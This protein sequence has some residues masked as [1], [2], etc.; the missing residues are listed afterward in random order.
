M[1]P[2]EAGFVAPVLP[3][4]CNPQELPGRLP[5]IREIEAAEMTLPCIWPA[6][7][8]RIVVVRE[9]F[10]V[11]YGIPLLVNGNEGHA[12]MLLQGIPMI[13][14]L[15]A[16]YHHEDKMFLVM[17]YMPGKSLHLVWE[18]MSEQDK[19]GVTRQLHDTFAC[20]RELVPPS[21]PAF[22]N[23]TGGPVPQRFFMTRSKDPS[24]TGPFNNEAAF[25]H[26]MA[27]HLREDEDRNGMAHAPSHFLERHLDTAMGR[28]ACV[29]THGDLQPK[30]IIVIE[31]PPSTLYADKNGDEESVPLSS[32][33]TLSGVVD[34]ENAG[35]MPSYWEYA[36]MFV[37]A[38]WPD[39]WT[40]W[41]ESILD[42][43]PSESAM[44]MF[45]RR[46]FDGF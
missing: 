33:F 31:T 5:T 30:N 11:K 14:K 28:H 6:A 18:D 1:A 42:A 22:G 35:W 46:N 38:S 21:P 45:V 7:K 43:W 23:I 29:L 41:F 3:Y 24:I 9:L 26:A 2:T 10:L 32:R 40:G 13:P 36:I 39:D 25:H 20:V 4:F 16:M 17:Q 19:I 44:L 12:L 37:F 8:K 34:W 27:L 15:Y